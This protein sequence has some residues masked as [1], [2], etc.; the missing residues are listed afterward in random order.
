LGVL[1]K[2]GLLDRLFEHLGSH[3]TPERCF[4]LIEETPVEV[5]FLFIF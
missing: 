5:S 1:D 2:N 4:S 3:Q